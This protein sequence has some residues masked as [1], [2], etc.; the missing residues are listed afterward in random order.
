[1]EKA[2]IDALVP[3]PLSESSQDVLTACALP[4]AP[5]RMPLQD[6]GPAAGLP[7]PVRE[8]LRPH[9]AVRS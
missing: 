5:L 8:W 9:V 7:T 3:A 1:M 6:I 4:D 2:V